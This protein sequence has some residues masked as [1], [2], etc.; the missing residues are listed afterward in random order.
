MGIVR[1]FLCLQRS[2]QIESSNRVRT[3]RGSRCCRLDVFRFME[4]FWHGPITRWQLAGL[5]FEKLNRLSIPNKR[6]ASSASSRMDFVIASWRVKKR[7]EMSKRS[8]PI[9]CVTI[10]AGLIWLFL[11]TV[12]TLLCQVNK[13]INWNPQ[14]FLFNRR[15]D[16]N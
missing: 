11:C 13:R 12:R 1:W 14:T 7:K 10:K 4:V 3:Q 5:A 2:H 15:T 16:T 9:L 8:L 6:A